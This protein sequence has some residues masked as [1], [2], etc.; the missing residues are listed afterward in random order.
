MFPYEPH[1]Q[2]QS[3]PQVAPS[4][5]NN[6]SSSTFASTSTS[7]TPS[8]R[9]GIGMRRTAGY[10]ASSVS[11]ELCRVSSS[12]L[13]SPCLTIDNRFSLFFVTKQTHKFDISALFFFFDVHVRGL[14]DAGIVLEQRSRSATDGEAESKIVINRF[15]F[16]KYTLFV[17]R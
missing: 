2:M 4:S 3:A 14:S 7:S 1:R 15:M 6:A 8:L 9:A 16:L 17:W 11:C 13:L 5:S 12:E 10:N